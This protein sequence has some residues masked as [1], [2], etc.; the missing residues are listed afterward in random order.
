MRKKGR[1]ERK[2]RGGALSSCGTR[3]SVFFQEHEYAP[4]DTN[5][6]V[7]GV[8]NHE[9]HE[10]VWVWYFQEHGYAPIDTNVY[11]GIG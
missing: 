1:R 9:K 11:G 3:M 10:W 6:Y 2:G 7:M 4:I 8:G 5:A